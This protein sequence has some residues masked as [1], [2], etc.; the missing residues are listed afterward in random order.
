MAISPRW[1]SAADR[2]RRRVR[3]SGVTV[4]RA[5]LEALRGAAKARGVAAGRLL[6]AIAW[7]A[8]KDAQCVIKKD[9]AL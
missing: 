3:L 5:F 1:H 2:D 6:E 8:L 4:D 7:E 9:G